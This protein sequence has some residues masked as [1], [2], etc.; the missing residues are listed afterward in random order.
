MSQINFFVV[1]FVIYLSVLPRICLA[2]RGD[3]YLIYGMKWNDF[4]NHFGSNSGSDLSIG[5]GFDLNT[6]KASQV[7]FIKTNFKAGSSNTAVNGIIM[8]E[9]NYISIHEEAYFDIF[10]TVGFTK[11]KFG[12]EGKGLLN[13]GVGVSHQLSE[14]VQWK[15]QIKKL[16]PSNDLASFSGLQLGFNLAYKFGNRN[17]RRDAPRY[18]EKAGETNNNELSSAFSCKEFNKEARVC[19]DKNKALISDLEGQGLVFYFDFDQVKIDKK[20]DK[21]IKALVLALERHPDL[22]IMLQGHTDSVGM[23]K[24]NQKLSE[25]RAIQVRDVM[26]NRFGAPSDRILALGF[27]E[28]RPAE[29]NTSRDGRAKNRRVVMVGLKTKMSVGF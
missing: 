9:L 18:G 3:M 11:L 19:F 15:I 26:I 10:S 5:V 27:G 29:G 16:F 22:E 12:A 4:Q 8:N 7:E 24:Y 6:A 20:Y 13:F 23:K 14:G 17:G 28:D 2:D 25:R 1:V 21:K